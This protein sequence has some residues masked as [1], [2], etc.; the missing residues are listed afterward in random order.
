MVDAD[1]FG[2]AQR[3]G[4]AQ[5]PQ[6]AVAQPGEVARAGSDQAAKLR[7]GQ[8]RGLARAAAMAAKDA[9]E[10]GANGRVARGHY[11]IPRRRC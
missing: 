11:S 6:G 1:Q 10:R 9:A 8:G 3:P 4:K 5:Q 2:A 7:G